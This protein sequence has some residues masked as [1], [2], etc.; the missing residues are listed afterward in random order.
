MNADALA[1]IAVAQLAGDMLCRDRGPIAALVSRGTNWNK[2]ANGAS[3]REVC[4]DSKTHETIALGV[5]IVV[6]FSPRYRWPPDRY[7]RGK[8]LRL[9]ITALAR[10]LV[11]CGGASGCSSV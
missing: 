3:A 1:W 8:H 4:R 6:M 2:S 9:S 5:E 11:V 10:F 7:G